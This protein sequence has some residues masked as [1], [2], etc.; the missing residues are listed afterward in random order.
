[1][2][3]G[4]NRPHA[5]VGIVG[6]PMDLGAGRR[7]V[8]MGPYAIRYSGLEHEIIKDRV[9]AGIAQAR[10]EGKPHGRPKSAAL[11]EKRVKQLHAKGL[12]KSEIARQLNIGRTSVRRILSGIPE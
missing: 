12:S 9:R 8:D 10:K 1:M 4:N 6:V 7:G 2:S 11:Q 5:E 3:P